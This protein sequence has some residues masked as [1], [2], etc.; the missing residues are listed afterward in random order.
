MAFSERN[1]LSHYIVLILLLGG[2]TIFKKIAIKNCEKSK[3]RR[4]S[5]CAPLRIDSR[6]ILIKFHR[7]FRAENVNVHLYKTFSACRYI[8]PTASVKLREGGPKTA[9]NEHFLMRT[10]SRTGSKFSRITLWQLYTWGSV[11]VYPYYGFSL[12]RQ[13]APQQNA[14]SRTVFLT[15]FAAFWGRI[16]SAIMDQFGRSFQHLLKE[17]RCTLQRTKRF[18]AMSIGGAGR[19]ANVRRK[20][21]KT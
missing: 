20:F 18:V 4:K 12:R 17:Y 8:A 9:R 5:L 19:F 15:N 7:W 13:M 16:A 6:N 2:A 10:K 21:S 14:Q 11:V 1:V 3:N